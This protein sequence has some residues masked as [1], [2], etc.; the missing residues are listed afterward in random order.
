MGA[1]WSWMD[2]LYKNMHVVFN[3]Q[4]HLGNSSVT[5]VPH[6]HRDPSLVPSTSRE[7]KAIAHF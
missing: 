2:E 7:P 6:K 3:N 4:T 1:F 5:N